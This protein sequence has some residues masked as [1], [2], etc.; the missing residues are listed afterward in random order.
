MASVST[1]AITFAWAF[2]FTPVSTARVLNSDMVFPGTVAPDAATSLQFLVEGED[3]DLIWLARGCQGPLSLEWQ[4]GALP[5]WSSQFQAATWTHDDDIATPQGGSALA[6]ATMPGGTPVP[7]TAGN[8][9]LA[10]T[11]GTTRVTPTVAEVAVNLGLS[12]QAVDSYN[13]PEGIAQYALT[14]GERATC[15]ML[16]LADDESWSDIYAAGTTYRMACQ[17][18]VSGG[19][20]LGLE[21]PMMELISEP[22]LEDRNGL[23]W[24]R[25]QW[26]ALED[27]TSTD[28]ATDIRR[29][30]WRLARG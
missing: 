2:S 20:L 28:Q 9:V 3:R 18:G 5:M 27:T 24:W 30:I 23:S 7:V 21:M 13:G 16:I 17:A 1:D 12:W 14:R 19:G 29:A 4:L 6:V 10:P 11:G 8:L 15:S 22:T 25:L 26:G